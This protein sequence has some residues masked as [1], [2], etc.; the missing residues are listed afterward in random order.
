MTLLLLCIVPLGTYRDTHQP[1][2]LR[3]LVEL[4]Q[5]RG[6]VEMARA[7]LQRVHINKQGGPPLLSTSPSGKQGNPGWCRGGRCRH[8]DNLVEQ[9]CTNMCQCN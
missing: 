5:D 6:G 2:Q 8:M 9:V 7:I 4:L 3:L 1:A